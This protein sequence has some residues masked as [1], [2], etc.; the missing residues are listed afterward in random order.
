M[1]DERPSIRD[2][3]AAMD[4]EADSWEEIS[5]DDS[6]YSVKEYENHEDTI[7]DFAETAGPWIR[8]ALEVLTPEQIDLVDRKVWPDDLPAVR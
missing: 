6:S 2:T 7:L 8:A 5:G 4:E 1:S 3:I